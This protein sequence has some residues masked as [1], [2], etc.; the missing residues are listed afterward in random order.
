MNHLKL[1]MISW[2]VYK[3]K[4]K[5]EQ[6]SEARKWNESLFPKE[7]ENKIKQYPVVFHIIFRQITQLVL[8]P[9]PYL[10][11]ARISRF[12]QQQKKHE[13]PAKKT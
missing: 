2:A 5:E 12:L 7:C 4:L 6:S 1:I 8:I 10:G 11:I 9:Y 13:N 3:L